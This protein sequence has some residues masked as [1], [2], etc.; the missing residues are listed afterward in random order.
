MTS[1]PGV[2]LNSNDQP[3]LR[4]PPKL[5][6]AERMMHVQRWV[7]HLPIPAG[8]SCSNWTYANLQGYRHFDEDR[9][10][11]PPSSRNYLSSLPFTP[12]EEQMMIRF[13]SPP[14]DYRHNQASAA[15]QI[16]YSS[17]QPH[18]TY[19]AQRTSALH[20]TTANQH[21]ASSMQQADEVAATGG[22]DIPPCIPQCKPGA[23][24][25]PE[26]DG[27]GCSRFFAEWETRLISRLFHE[28]FP[29]RPEPM[30]NAGTL[31]SVGEV[32][33]R[34]ATSRLKDTRTPT[35]IRAKIK[36]MQSSGTWIE[37]Q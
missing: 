14:S 33:S 26:A 21:L 30:G 16:P 12:E 17:N 28:Y 25:R 3:P 5:K 1:T 4:L 8:G 36:R 11:T 19:H 22:T 18:I 23:H 35:A 10:L 29:G 32:R 27:P 34:I 20:Q 9:E 6:E 2:S 24:H 37:Y 7:N 31:P 15:L 13:F